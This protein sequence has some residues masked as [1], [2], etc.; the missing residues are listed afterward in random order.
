MG[1]LNKLNDNHLRIPN[2]TLRIVYC[3][4]DEHG[5]FHRKCDKLEEATQWIEEKMA[6]QTEREKI[7]KARNLI[8]AYFNGHDQK[9]VIWFKT[10]NLNLGNLSP[11]QLI[12]WGKIDKLLMYIESRLYEKL[13]P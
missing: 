11:N 12:Q 5:V 4:V 7:I 10:K 2:P 8:Q 13:E 1:V 3:V 9:K 6:Q